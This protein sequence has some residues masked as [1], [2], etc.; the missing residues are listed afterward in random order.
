MADVC[1]NGAEEAPLSV[2]DGPHSRLYA[3]FIAEF[4]LRSAATVA[5]A[6]ENDYESVILFL[7]IT[8]QNSHTLM[9]NQA[10]RKR[11]ASFR[12]PI[13]TELVRPVS[14]LSLSRSTG[15]PRE[16]VRRKVARLIE[17][18]FVVEADGGLI[19]P[20][21]VHDNP[22]YIDVLRPQEALLRRLM[23]LTGGALGEPEPGPAE[24]A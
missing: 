1:D 5:P 17:R 10:H 15:L 22:A 6:F 19:V 16:T 11:Y 21:Y 13:P 20:P 4:M 9:L 2:L 23:T 8:T 7:A 18:G 24:K 12:E 14:R 3:Y